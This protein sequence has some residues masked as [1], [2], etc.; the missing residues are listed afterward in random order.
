[1]KL[2]DYSLLSAFFLFSALVA[3]EPV[4]ALLTALAGGATPVTALFEMVMGTGA[5]AV[6]STLESAVPNGAGEVCLSVL[7]INPPT[8]SIEMLDGDDVKGIVC[9]VGAGERDLRGAVGVAREMGSVKPAEGGFVFDIVG[10]LEVGLED[11]EGPD[12]FADSLTELSAFCCSSS[13]GVSNSTGLTR[14]V[15]CTL[16]MSFARSQ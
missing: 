7:S 15:A 5:F 9:V 8:F 3:I 2:P 13:D 16:V 4:A 10:A 1:M 14:G 6:V 11:G 12:F